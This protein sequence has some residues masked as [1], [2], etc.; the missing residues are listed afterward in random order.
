MCVRVCEEGLAVGLV[1]SLDDAVKKVF[2][3]D[4]V[5]MW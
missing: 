3:G 5:V 1:L 2:G 4:E